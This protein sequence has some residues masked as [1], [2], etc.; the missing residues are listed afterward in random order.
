MNLSYRVWFLLV[1]TVAVIII[2]GTIL[3]SY[4][5]N[6]YIVPIQDDT[7]LECVG[8]GVMMY[9]EEKPVER[10]VTLPVQTVYA[11]DSCGLSSVVCPEEI[12]T[13]KIIHAIAIM[14]TGNGKNIKN[15]QNNITG[16]KIAGKYAD[17]V[18]QEACFDYSVD[19][20]ERAYSG[21]PL[22]KALAKWKVGERG[23]INQEALNYISKIK[24]L[25]E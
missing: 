3:E 18:S 13:E 23:V 12:T 25:I 9:C 19:L 16:I 15:G 11:V 22:E 21:L 17:F 14:E 1:A 24:M 10:P 2:V 8:G 6:A 5:A 4:R 20:W 7:I